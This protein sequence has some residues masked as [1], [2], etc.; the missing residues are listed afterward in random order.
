MSFSY[1]HPEI[2][3]EVT[4]NC[5][6]TVSFKQKLDYKKSESSLIISQHNYQISFFMNWSSLEVVDCFFSPLHVKIS[7][8]A[9]PEYLYYDKVMHIE[10]NGTLCLQKLNTL[11]RYRE[12]R[13]LRTLKP[14]WVSMILLYFTCRPTRSCWSG[15]SLPNSMPSSSRST[16]GFVKWFVL[17][18]LPCLRD[19]GQST[20]L[21]RYISFS[22]PAVLFL[23]LWL[24]KLLL[25]FKFTNQ[26]DVTLWCNR[27]IRR[28]TRRSESYLQP[29]KLMQLI[30]HGINSRTWPALPL[31]YFTVTRSFPILDGVH[32]G[33]ERGESL[34]RPATVSV[35]RLRD[36][37]R[38]AGSDQRQSDHFQHPLLFISSSPHCQSKNK[39]FMPIFLCC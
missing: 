18:R 20:N 9:V 8:D 13:P 2:S 38:N 29:S 25:M 12:K 4:G 23:L 5:T 17:T 7:K 28:E 36:W 33:S 35:I 22:F 39:R 24:V 34:L 3:S 19:L 10:N 21:W 30:G 26:C 14:G 27:W 1:Q 37:I 32:E 15:L 31:G 11:E 16:A 6:N